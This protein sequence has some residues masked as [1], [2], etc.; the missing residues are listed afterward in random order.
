MCQLAPSADGGN[1]Q[2][3]RRRYQS[4]G[5]FLRYHSLDGTS[6]LI[7]REPGDDPGVD[8]DVALQ[9]VRIEE[10]WELVV[11]DQNPFGDPPRVLTVF[12]PADPTWGA[13]ALFEL[14]PGVMPGVVDDSTERR[15]WWHD[16]PGRDAPAGEERISFTTSISVQGSDLEMAV[17]RGNSSGGRSIVDSSR[18]SIAVN[19]ARTSLNSHHPDDSLV[20]TRVAA[21]KQSV[22]H[23]AR[24]SFRRY[25]PEGLVS[26]DHQWRMIHPGGDQGRAVV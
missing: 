24:T 20:H 12:G 16:L 13:H 5:L 19:T 4:V 22:R 21:G 10:D 8:D 7:I 17:I 14:R 1:R 26:V 25:S 3:L 2:S 18:L 9:I 23:F 6:P 11:T 15:C